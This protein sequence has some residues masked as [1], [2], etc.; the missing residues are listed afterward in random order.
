[1]RLVGIDVSTG[2]TGIA[3]NPVDVGANAKDA[4]D[5]LAGVFEEG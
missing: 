4:G 2:G 5:V 1:L 3:P